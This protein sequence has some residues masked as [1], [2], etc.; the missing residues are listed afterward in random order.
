MS[1]LNAALVCSVV[2]SLSTAFP[3]IWRRHHPDLDACYKEWAHFAI[4]SQVEGR[5]N[6]DTLLKLLSVE[7]QKNRKTSEYYKD[8]LAH[9]A[10]SSQAGNT[11]FYDTV[12]ELLAVQTQQA[13]FPDDLPLKT[14]SIVP[15]AVFKGKLLNS[16][17]SRRRQGKR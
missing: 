7:S 10:V 17:H 9:Y 8:E 16:D 4:S 5:T 2:V 14:R 13:P 15:A 12:L 1:V 3:G 6:Y 11:E